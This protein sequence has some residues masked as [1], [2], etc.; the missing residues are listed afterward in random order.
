MRVYLLY[1]GGTIGCGGSPLA[2]MAGPDFTELVL[3]MPGLQ[4]FQVA[5]Y[6]NLHYTLDYL[7]TVLDSS[8]MA[9]ADWIVIARRI[10]ANYAEY[11]GFVILHG[12]DTMSWTASALSFLLDGLDK[13][14]I[15]TGSQLPLGQSLNDALPNLVGAVVLAATSRIPEVCLFFNSLLFR[16]N[17][18]AKTAT[19]EFAAFASPKFPPLAIVGAHSTISTSLILP[20]P[21]YAQSLANP[22]HL[23]KVQRFLETMV[24]TIADFSV[25]SVMLFPGIQ[26]TTMLE[27]ILQKTQPPVRGLILGAFGAGN[28]PLSPEFLGHIS[29]AN[30]QGVVIVDSTQVIKGSANNMIYQTGS[31]LLQAGAINGYDLTPEAALTKLVYLTALGLDQQEIKTRMQMDLR[32]EMFLIKSH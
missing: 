6:D 25:L 29:G 30:N 10:L 17:R 21:P 11:D 20:L 5:G 8:D 13:P 9:P 18:S 14:V 26:H 31:G 16:G 12:T 4:H 28:A 3:S 23:V 7:E 15:L 32:G 1:T 24:Q 19:N 22:D 2:P 27:A